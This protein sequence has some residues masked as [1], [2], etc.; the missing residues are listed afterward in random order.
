MPARTT[1]TE[2]SVK[3][4]K[5]PPPGAQIDHFEKLK[6]GLTLTLRLSYGGTRAWRVGYYVNGRPKA[7]TIGRYPELGVAAARKAAFEFDPKAANAAAQAGSFKEVAENWIKHYVAAKGL[8]SQPEI[9]RILNYYVYPVWGRRPFFK[10]QR[11]DVNELLDRLVEKHSAI[12]AD[13]VLSVLRSMMNWF[14]TRDDNYS[15]PIVKGMQRDQ[16]SAS[17]RAR[18]RILDD[19]EIR[20][21]WNAAE[22]N[23]TYGA[24]QRVPLIVV[25]S[26][27]A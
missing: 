12:Q 23:G 8:R 13:N 11:A 19:D 6:R 20:A 18:S 10:I 17:E 2:A 4:F 26:P 5:L 24:L 15:S 3:R 1:F 21:V 7:K 25:H 22:Q 27:N 14:A 16:R 9:E